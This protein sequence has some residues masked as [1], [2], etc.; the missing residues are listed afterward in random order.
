MRLKNKEIKNIAK[1]AKTFPMYVGKNKFF[2]SR[3]GGY[4]GFLLTP[5]R[6]R[7]DLNIHDRLN[8]NKIREKILLI[9]Y[10]S[11]DVILYNLDLELEDFPIKI[12]KSSTK[13]HYEITTKKC[14]K[15]NLINPP[16]VDKASYRVQDTTNELVG[17]VKY[18]KDTLQ[19]ENR[20]ALQWTYID[21]SVITNRPG[22]T[23]KDDYFYKI[24]GVVNKK[25]VTM[26]EV[27]LFPIIMS[28]I[29]ISPWVLS[30]LILKACGVVETETPKEEQRL[31]PPTIEIFHE[32]REGEIEGGGYMREVKS[33]ESYKEVYNKINE[34]NKKWLEE[35]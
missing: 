32:L 9:S 24:R 14:K 1:I 27:I 6:I 17:Y 10:R 18:L 4:F 26:T 23:I 21:T 7:D 8:D 31:H 22:M 2:S 20:M 33:V 5:I 35:K 12:K 11:G 16:F 19:E 30:F 34:R 15:K 29:Y 25:T 3:Y 28:L 13:G